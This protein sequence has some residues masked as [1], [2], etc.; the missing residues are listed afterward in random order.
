M[1]ALYVQKGIGDSKKKELP[2]IRQALA[3][4]Q[5]MN[6]PLIETSKHDLNMV[7]S[8]RPHQ[9]IVLDASPLNCDKMDVFPPAD[10]VSSSRWPVWLCLDEITDPQ[11]LGAVIRTAFFLGA[12]GVLLCSKNSAPLSGVVSK[13]SSGDDDTF[14]SL[15]ADDAG[16]RQGQGVGRGRGERG[17]RLDA[18]SGV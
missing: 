8:N 13:A 12:D 15:S 4:A 14:L 1:H 6:I 5:K 9:G 7:T 16:G 3:R 2:A 11:N 17:R 18:L 10:A